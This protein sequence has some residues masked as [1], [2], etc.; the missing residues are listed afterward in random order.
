M[1]PQV[2]QGAQPG[3]ASAA[4]RA[5]VEGARARQRDRFG[6]RARRTNAAMS[7]RDLKRHGRLTP[8]AQAVL[9]HALTDLRL[10]ARAHHKVLRVARTI[11]DLAAADPMDAPHLAEA[12]QYRALDWQPWT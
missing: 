4:I 2:L 12:V 9:R 6:S 7:D 5:R 10:S 11:A 3:E 1:P 8:A